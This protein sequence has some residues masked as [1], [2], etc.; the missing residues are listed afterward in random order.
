MVYMCSAEGPAPVCLSLLGQAPGPTG[1]GRTYH[2]A[3]M[4][5]STWSRVGSNPAGARPISASA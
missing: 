2:A 4:V 3:R 5:A 1:S